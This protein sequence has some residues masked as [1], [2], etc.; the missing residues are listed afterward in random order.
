M[1][2]VGQDP[3]FSILLPTHNRPET[4]ALAIRSVLAQTVAD[5]ELLVVGDG[6]TD[7]T[8]D[9]VAG[10]AD[11]RIRWFDLPKAP[12]FGYVNRN[13]GLRE[14]RGELIAF[15]GHDN[16]FLPDH[17]ERTGMVFSRPVVQFAY[18]RPLY[19]RDDGVVAPFF[20]NL[21]VPRER[22]EFMT[23]RNT[24]P[25]TCVV[26]RRSAFDKVG[27]WPEEM[28]RGGDWDLWKRILQEFGPG[29]ARLVRS[30]TN[31]HFR[32]NWRPEVGWG[33]APLSYLFALHDA[34]RFWP[35]QLDLML[36]QADGLPQAQVWAMMARDPSAFATR[37]RNGCDVLQD[38]L[39][40][41]A[42]MDP[43]FR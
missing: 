6:C 40:W 31:L 13:I 21:A 5:W 34:G 8:A 39:S 12:G 41:N 24:L 22:T 32:A 1:V 33:P 18:V 10:F 27:M 2:G 19:I 20:V 23:Q 36:E 9:V 17:L 15:L 42:S 16:L 11:P 3:I 25:A 28:E 26:H 14:A 7:Q 30:A 35:K 38:M 43:A 29:A 37:L 4:L